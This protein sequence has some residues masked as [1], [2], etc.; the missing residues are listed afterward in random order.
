MLQK[1][2]PIFMTEK[3]L[4]YYKITLKRELF[5]SGGWGYSE[6]VMKQTYQDKFIKKTFREPYNFL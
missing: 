3:I 1:A 6:R 5:I 2:N 4:I